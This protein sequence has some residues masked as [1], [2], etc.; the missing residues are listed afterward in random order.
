MDNRLPTPNTLVVA[1]HTASRK[2]E[3]MR[4]E[5]LYELNGHGE[6]RKAQW[7]KVP[8]SMVKPSGIARRED[9]LFLQ[10]RREAIR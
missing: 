8:R 4:L 1:V 6:V 2:K 5:A 3:S 7:A 10:P 9:G